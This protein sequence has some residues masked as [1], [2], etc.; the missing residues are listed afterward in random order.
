MADRREFDVLVIGSTHMDLVAGAKRL[1]V[2]GE[3]MPGHSLSIHPGGKG[4]NQA[5]AAARA[6]ARTAMLGRVGRD[7]FGDRLRAAL[8]GAGVDVS[9]VGQDDE[10]AT[11]ASTV[12]TGEDGDYA[13]IIVPG[14]S[15]RL[16]PERVR[17]Q[18]ARI[19]GAGMVMGQ[20]EILPDA[21]AE[22][23]RIAQ[24][25]GGTTML[26]AAPVP[27]DL[28]RIPAALWETTDILLVNR[29]EL[30]MLSG[31]DPG[32]PGDPAARAR[33]IAEALG[34]PTV[35][36]TLGS[37]GVVAVRAGATVREP[38]WVVDVIDT[39]GAG[40]AFAGTLAATLADGMPFADALRRANAAGAIAVTRAGGHAAAP[41][42]QDVDA[43]LASGERRQVPPAATT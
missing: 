9:L 1:P 25:A 39:V 41:T 12:L 13:S 26:N 16:T 14:A 18:A 19:R 38:G 42:P 37:E 15:L 21:T 4:G 5:V 29:V 10:V 31:A 28:A 3:T 6:G 17:E 33:G 11:G 8:A 43:M 23:F 2:R 32:V 34:V 35:I 20:L 40:D 22:A 7:D 30:E 36:V 27:D 24:E